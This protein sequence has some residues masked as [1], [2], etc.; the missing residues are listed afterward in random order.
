MPSEEKLGPYVLWQD[1][2]YEGWHP[3]SYPTLKDALLGERYNSFV[4]T[5]V[6]EFDVNEGADNAKG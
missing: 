5:R 3:T 2:G 6:V 1:Y 4:I